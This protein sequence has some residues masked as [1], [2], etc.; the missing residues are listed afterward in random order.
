VWLTVSEGGALDVVGIG[1]TTTPKNSI[2]FWHALCG[3][4]RGIAVCHG[5]TS[6][7]FPRPPLT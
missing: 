3:G 6:Y 5:Q 4:D 2:S 7:L 1:P